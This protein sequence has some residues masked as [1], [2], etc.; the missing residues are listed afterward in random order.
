[1][2]II[3]ED[4]DLVAAIYDGAFEQPLWCTFLERLRSAVR[5]DGTAILVGA[6]DGGTL[7]PIEL[8]AG[9]RFGA[10]V[11]SLWDQEQPAR[12]RDGRVYDLA[13]L[14]ERVDPGCVVAIRAEVAALRMV[15]LTEPSG[16]AARLFCARERGAFTSADGALLN[17]LAPHVRRAL[18]GYVALERETSRLSIA[19]EVVERLNFGWI[20]LDARG[21]VRDASREAARLLRH[22]RGL[23]TARG[24]R[25][26]AADP[27]AERRLSEALRTLADPDATVR[28]QAI[29]VSEDPWTEL[30]LTRPNAR[31]ARSAGAPALIAYVQGDSRSDADRHEQIAQLFGLLPSE[32]RLAL[33]LSR[34]LSIADAARA[35]GLTI[36]TARNYSKKIY[37]KTGTRGQPDL[38]RLILTSVLALA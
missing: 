7:R 8:T 4:N 12:L 22:G 16:V 36:E 15:R 33:A 21:H 30:L 27:R 26:L 20:A 38:V 13:E 37:A 25:L 17:K 6:G 1:M 18:R 23:K 24:G 11:S 14:L 3:L 34:G 29:V 32:A 35:L 9:E 10:V 5:A 28:T 2:A 31:A 19:S